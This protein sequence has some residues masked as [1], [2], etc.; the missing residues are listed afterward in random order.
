MPEATLPIVS[1]VPGKPK[2]RR[3]ELAKGESACNYCAAKC[4]RYF[5]LPIDEPTEWQEFDYMRWFLL[6][7]H[8][9]VFIEEG[10][11][12]L[13]VETPCRHLRDDNLCGIYEKRPQIC[14]DYHTDNCEYDD[15]WTYDHLWET[16]EQIEEYA[17]A[18]LGPRKGDSFRSPKPAQENA[19]SC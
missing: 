13:L 10:S 6:H 16:P 18:V 4:C 7:R 19:S 5:A 14:R 15:D 11:W 2:P 12:Y 9:V 8:A 1:A 3:E 17:L